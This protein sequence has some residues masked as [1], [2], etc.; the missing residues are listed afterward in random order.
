MTDS[1]NQDVTPEILRART[2]TRTQDYLAERPNIP[3]KQSYAYG[4]PG[5]VSAPRK[6]AAKPR[7]VA[8][9]IERQLDDAA[10]EPFSPD[11]PN[12]LPRVV[13]EADPLESS[14][15]ELTT[16]PDT[17]D[18]RDQENEVGSSF[19]NEGFL[20][21]RAWIP[22]LP[23]FS[24]EGFQESA[25]YWWETLGGATVQKY[26]IIGAHLLLVLLAFSFAW[27]AVSCIFPN[28]KLADL[29]SPLTNPFG[30]RFGNPFAFR[31]K[32][33]TPSDDSTEDS[34]RFLTTY[35]YDHLRDRIND[36]EKRVATSVKTAR[37]VP[38]VNFFAPGSGVVVD[39]YLTSPTRQLAQSKSRSARLLAWL[40]DIPKLTAPPPSAAFAPW[41][42]IG[43][44]WCA[45]PGGG[46]SQLTVMLPKN[47]IP[48][49]LVVEH[50][51]MEATLDPG[52]TPKDIEMWVEIQDDKKRE[53]VA[54]AAFSLF[55]KEDSNLAPE[56][57]NTN[58]F[59]TSKS[60]DY[61]WVRVGRWRYKIFTDNYIQTFSV[62]VPLDHFSAPTNKIAIRTLSTWGTADYVCLYRLKLHGLLANSSNMTS[63][64]LK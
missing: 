57:E 46:R 2:N 34:L 59:S 40:M 4:A 8:S 58:L 62:P 7:P 25:I 44:C 43:D 24:W 38:R 11:D 18:E 26:T 20:S 45:P 47:V 15:G 36:V 3:T 27:Q 33:Y 50:I 13:A 12:P 29:R 10:D 48:T 19:L 28:F 22:A 14:D 23:W 32:G 37:K 60:L 5:K 63:T 41:D 30:D 9:A 55:K 52:A 51:P 16:P 35:Q 6:V 21:R 17:D 39:P 42:D 49:D 61:K 1:L 31:N 54:N 64:V 53:A 56:A